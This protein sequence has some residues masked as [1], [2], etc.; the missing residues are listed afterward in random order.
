MNL[1]K[2]A[3]LLFKYWFVW[4]DEFEKFRVRRFMDDDK[5][6]F[7]EVQHQ[8]THCSYETCTTSWDGIRP[9]SRFSSKKDAIFILRCERLKS[10]QAWR[11][12]KLKKR[13]QKVVFRQP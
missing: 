4:K 9:D 11:L 10:I 6:I 5:N 13:T 1:F 12:Q 2:K 3:I 8:V 7:Y